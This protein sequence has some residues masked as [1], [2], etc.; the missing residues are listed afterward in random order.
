MSRGAL[1]LLGLMLLLIYSC[2]DEIDFDVPREFQKSTVIVGKIVRGDIPRVE[3]TVQKVFDFTFEE[4]IFATAQEVKVIS[5]D[6]R[7]A[8]VPLKRT[9]RY[10]LLITDEMD[11]DVEVGAEYSLEVKLFDGQHFKSSFE[12]LLPVPDIG[13]VNKELFAKQIVNFEGDTVLR[14]RIRCS[15]DVDLS[16]SAEDV[17]IKWEF[18]NTYKQT[19]NNRRVCY[20][21]GI[22]SFD[23][24][25]TLDRREVEFSQLV[26]Y[27]LLELVV[28]DIMSE[29]Y[30][31]E[32]I[33]ESVSDGA[34]E[35]WDQIA[36]LSQN[37]GS[38]Y[39]PPPGQ[40]ST[41]FEKVNEEEG[42]VFG[43]F[44]A[45]QQDSERI[46]IDSTF[47]KLQR[48]VCPRPPGPGGSGIV[49]DDCFDCRLAPFSTTVRPEYWVN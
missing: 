27:E 8:I 38:F 25:A 9:G 18:A 14:D 32:I 31:L 7:E 15:L 13:M 28:L 41:N 3:V 39:E 35:F 1:V 17:N 42:S 33:Q 19:D 34:L 12:K 37:S 21:F 44:Y 10:E 22:P 49:E 36:G 24:I 20:I 45:T 6:G 16:Q 30:S 29:G 40:I 26:D 2:I 43:Y 11:F 23:A 4:E 46:F 5:D 47:T 48:E